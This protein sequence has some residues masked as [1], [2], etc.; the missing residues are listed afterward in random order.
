MR[1]IMR[2]LLALVL[3]G[4]TM[5]VA[6]GETVTKSFTYTTPGT[7]SPCVTVTDQYGAST[8]QCTTVTVRGNTPP[9]VAL[10]A[11][12]STGL[13]PLTTT[14][15]ATSTDAEGDTMTYTWTD[16]TTP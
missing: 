8:K 6:W 9:V 16:G 10:V 5:G 2:S 15:T 14:L 12:P 1:T 11:S 3:V 4:L 7:F 13:A